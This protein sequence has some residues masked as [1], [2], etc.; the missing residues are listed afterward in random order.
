MAYKTPEQYKN[1]P[2]SYPSDKINPVLKQ[3]VEWYLA[4]SEAM[5]SEYVGGNCALPCAFGTPDESQRSLDEMWAYAEGRQNIDKIKGF[6]LKRQ[7]PNDPNSRFVTKTNISWAGYAYL[8][9][10]LDVMCAFNSKIDYEVNAVAVDDDSMDT[11]ETDREY[12]KYYMNK[13]VRALMDK[14]GFVPNMKIN[15][16]DIGAEKEADIDTLMDAGGFNLQ[17]EIA[18]QVVCNKTKKESYFAVLQDMVFK[19][20]IITGRTGLRRYINKA[21]NTPLADHID[22]R[23]A[24]LQKS[25]YFDFR[26]K[27]RW[28][29][30][31]FMTIPQIREESDLTEAQLTM[32][33]KDYAWM[34][35]DY[36][37]AMESTGYLSGIGRENYYGQYGVD[38]INNVRIMVLEWQCL[39]LDIERYLDDKRESNGA[40]QYKKIGFEYE[41]DEKSIKSG[42]KIDEKGIIKKYEAK[43]IIG[44]RL[45]ISKGQAAN[46]KYKGEKGDRTPTLDGHFVQLGNMSIMERCIPHVDDMNSALFKRRNAIATLPPAPR[47]VIE[48]GILDNVLLGDKLQE[49]EDL[50]KAFEER[51]ILIVNRRDEFERPVQVSGKTVEFVPTGIIEDI[52]MFS[53]EIVQ[54]K[55]AI[56]DVTGVNDITAAQTPQERTGLGVSKLAQVASSNALFPTFNLFKYLFEPFFEGIV[57]MWQI[58]ST[59]TER[60]LPYIAPG[61]NITKI[62]TINKEFGKCKFHLRVDMVIGEDEK[63]MIL[64]EIGQLKDARRQNG[65]SGG[66]TGSQWLKLYDLV[67]SGNRKMA[68]FILAQIEEMQKRRDLAITREGQQSTIEGQQQTVMVSERYKQQTYRVEG[69]VKAALALI[70]ACGQRKNTLMDAKAKAIPGVTM[71]DITVIDEE[72]DKCDEEIAALL[73]MIHGDEQTGQQQPQLGMGSPQ[74]L[75]QAS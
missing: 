59:G 29:V 42:A 56:K 16:D 14:V 54:S 66:I 18:A 70:T 33:A 22:M 49:P 24:V 47:M 48:Q 72:I 73:Q 25:R 39:S 69:S 7:Q 8:P 35:P 71:P 19:D 3:D 53:N 4:Q 40:N 37:R 62:F 50:I 6:L 13:Q 64:R 21:T 51:G 46:Q 27:T 32:L 41:L 38:P 9:K 61:S 52:T 45:F 17:T 58:V 75:P 12:I 15:P 20:L 60:K 26:D 1:Q 5:W 30:V 28:G 36:A 63:E 2:V 43:W 67:M 11:K 23:Y 55:E 65:G 34:N 44:S 68:M 57:D 31:R 74:Q 10:M